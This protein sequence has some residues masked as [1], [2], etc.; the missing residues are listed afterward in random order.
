LNAYYG[1]Y[2][3]DKRNGIGSFSTADDEH[4]TTEWVNGEVASDIYDIDS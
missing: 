1:D 2:A 3:K 4:F